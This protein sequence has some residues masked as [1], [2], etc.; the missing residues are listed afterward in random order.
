MSSDRG[1]SRFVHFIL[2][3]YSVSAERKLIRPLIRNIKIV[4]PDLNSYVF[5]SLLFHW[6]CEFCLNLDNFFAISV[7]FFNSLLN[8]KYSNL[9]IVA[10]FSNRSGKISSSV[11]STYLPTFLDDKAEVLAIC[12]AKLYWALFCSILLSIVLIFFLTVILK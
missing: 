4:T 10:A 6:I 9:L 1:C 5:Y 2:F 7:C 12:Q 3:L 11:K 8:G